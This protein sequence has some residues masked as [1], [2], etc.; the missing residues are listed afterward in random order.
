MNKVDFSDGRRGFGRSRTNLLRAA[1]PV[2]VEDLQLLDDGRLATFRR[3]QKQDFDHR[4]SR[5]VGHN[6]FRTPGDLWRLR[7]DVDLVGR[8]GEQLCGVAR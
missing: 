2:L 3:A 4:P 7:D 5:V 1:E 6:T 8:V